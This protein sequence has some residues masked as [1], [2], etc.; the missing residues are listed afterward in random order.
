MRDWSMVS[1]ILALLLKPR[2]I[3]LPRTRNKRQ[4]QRQSLSTLE[5]MPRLPVFRQ[6]M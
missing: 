5:A 1:L 3:R 6:L 4:C 2:P